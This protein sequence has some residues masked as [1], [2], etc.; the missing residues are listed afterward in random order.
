MSDLRQRIE[1][2][3]PRQFQILVYVAQHLSSKEIGLLLKSSPATIDSHIAAA[4]QKLGLS[5]RRE[6]ALKM[7]ELG[8]ATSQPDP[9]LPGPL[10]DSHHGGNVPSNRRDS[11]PIGIPTI[12]RS[13]GR[14]HARTSEGSGDGA[15]ATASRLGMGR[16]VLRCLL[17]AIYITLFFA[18]M[19]AGAFGVH[20]IVIQC[21][22]L[23]IDP[24]VLHVLKGVSYALV[25]F[26]AV[27]VITASGLLTFRFIRAIMRVDD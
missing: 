23:S 17:D 26:G 22:Q 16:V 15:Q 20:W 4:L 11:P 12:G 8:F 5:S 3:S 27:G 1:T 9:T 6:A 2:L 14:G 13:S 7:I 21:Q 25:L 10:A 24:F 18:G 19:S